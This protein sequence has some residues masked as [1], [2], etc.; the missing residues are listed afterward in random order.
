M[1]LHDVLNSSAA[2]GGASVLATSVT[3]WVKQW[4]EDRKEER[5]TKNNQQTFDRLLDMVQQDLKNRAELDQHNL[6]VQRDNAASLSR[7]ADGI[8]AIVHQ[9]KRGG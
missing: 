6:Q 1:S 9:D 2:T 4:W 8:M 5:V 7:L 3:F